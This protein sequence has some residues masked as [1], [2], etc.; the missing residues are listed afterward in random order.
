MNEKSDQTKI[1][2][3]LKR[4]KNLSMIFYTLSQTPSYPDEL[5]RALNISNEEV[6]NAIWFL[7][8]NKLIQELGNNG[9][10][11]NGAVR[12]FYPIILKKQKLAI[13]GLSQKDA[14]EVLK[15]LKFYFISRNGLVFLPDIRK[16]IFER[17]DKYGKRN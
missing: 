5:S 8:N 13:K 17:G 4:D 9:K 12:E 2:N 11:R 7:R 3:V 1:K 16:R 15:K 14:Y 10:S 6:K